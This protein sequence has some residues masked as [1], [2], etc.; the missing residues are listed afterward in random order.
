MP[1]FSTPDLCDIPRALRPGSKT[2]AEKRIDQYNLAR[3]IASRIGWNGNGGVSPSLDVAALN[4]KYGGDPQNK[5]HW[6][7]GE[8]RVPIGLSKDALD[9]RIN[10]GV[11]VF[12][13]ELTARGYLI[14]RTVTKPGVYPAL[15]RDGEK[16]LDQ[17]Q[18]QVICGVCYPKA[19]RTV[20]E[21]PKEW[22]EPYMRAGASSGGTS[23]KEG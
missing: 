16:I 23:G 2:T 7:V 18:W 13:K 19:E 10:W 21:L 4:E 15:G 1:N 12:H 8:F 20:I 17:R 9:T 3:S 5:L 11:G 14:E 6:M 22:V